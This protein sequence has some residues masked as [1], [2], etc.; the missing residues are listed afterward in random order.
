MNTV[1]DKC[2]IMSD[3][4][5]VRNYVIKRLK[6][7][8]LGSSQFVKMKSISHVLYRNRYYDIQKCKS[9]FFYDIYLTKGTSRGNME[10]IFAREF[11][12]DNNESLWNNVYNKKNKSESHKVM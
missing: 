1:H 10:S 3:V 6:N 9:K 12:F 8:D 4:H 5:I 2:N 11:R 7:V